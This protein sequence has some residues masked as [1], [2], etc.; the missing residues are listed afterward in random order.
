MSKH[1]IKRVRLNKRARAQHMNEP[2]LAAVRFNY[3]CTGCP[4]IRT[5][6]ALECKWDRQMSNHDFKRMCDHSIKLTYACG[7]SMITGSP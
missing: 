6:A 5:C 4:L 7:D 2:E 3:I 1:G